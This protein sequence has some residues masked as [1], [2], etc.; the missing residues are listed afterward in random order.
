[1]KKLEDINYALMAQLS[2]LR[3]NK[4]KK[5]KIQGITIKDIFLDTQ[6]LSQIKTD[7][8]DDPNHYPSNEKI[9]GVRGKLPE[10]IY[11]EEDKRLFLVYSLD[12]TEKRTLLFEN[13]VDGWQYLDCA[14]GTNIQNILFDKSLLE[15]YEESGFFGVAFQRND[16][17]I[18]AYRGTEFEANL[19]R[20]MRADLNIYLKKTD[21]QQ[22]EAV[23]FYEYIKNKYGSEKNIHI[24][25]HSLAGAIAQYV[26]FYA[27]CIGDKVI[28]TTW[29]GLGSFGSVLT[30]LEFSLTEKINLNSSDHTLIHRQK[31]MNF[32]NLF[33][34]KITSTGNKKL[35]EFYSTD[36]KILKAKRE[37]LVNTE[38]LINYF[39]D[40]DFVGGWLNGDWIGKKVLVNV[41]EKT[42]G[43]RFVVVE[44]KSE[45]LHLYGKTKI[46]SYFDVMGKKDVGLTF[47]NVN[48]FLVFMGDS[49]NIIPCVV[50][51]DFRK[52]AL[53]SI[54]RKK[55]KSYSALVEKGKEIEVRK[56]DSEL[57]NAYRDILTPSN[58]AI[59]N[60]K[61]LFSNMISKKELL[62]VES[63]EKE[64][65]FKS[66][67]MKVTNESDG[68][69]KGKI[70]LGEYNNVASLGGIEG[71]EPLEI[72]IYIEKANNEEK[73]ENVKQTNNINNYNRTKHGI[74]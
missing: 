58:R 21:I 8:Y 60:G 44:E 7:F 61:M 34:K 11:H 71:K 14:T 13:I 56:K 29:N 52:N 12:K 54:V 23:L 47:H 4:I 19:D 42:L 73:R 48:N 18:I 28:T 53:K 72:K 65:N 27:T 17:I 50:R 2:Y 5:E 64:N 46:S 15:K 37:E 66:S 51:Q 32:Q 6:I 24:T 57:F 67:D 41:K 35:I 16:D 30:S 59:G 55:V 25:G 63:F 1:M 45:H 36:L 26:H 40:E 20:D 10:Y 38:N 69:Y 33:K 22:V 68:D 9:N 62:F 49:G 74:N 43:D 70:I 3:W 31:L 39:M